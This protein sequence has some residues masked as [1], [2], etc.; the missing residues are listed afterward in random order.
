[1]LVLFLFSSSENSFARL[2][3]L[4]QHLEGHQ[5]LSMSPAPVLLFCTQAGLTRI[6]PDS[7]AIPGMR[8]QASEPS[9][10]RAKMCP[11]YLPSI[12]RTLLK[13]RAG[14]LWQCRLEAKWFSFSSLKLSIFHLCQAGFYFCS[15]AVLSIN[16]ECGAFRRSCRRREVGSQLMMDESSIIVPWPL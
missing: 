1:M 16:M 10:C 11:A 4:S 14:V 6:A 13:I 7:P 5:L 8:N 2:Q 9:L 12:S 3:Q 15:R